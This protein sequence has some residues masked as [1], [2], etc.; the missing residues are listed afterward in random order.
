VEGDHH[1]NAREQPRHQRDEERLEVV[2]VQEPHAVRPRC[3][4]DRA[5][6]GEIEPPRALE[7]E[8]LKSAPPRF[9]RQR[10]GRAGPHDGADDRSIGRDRGL[11]ERQHRAVRA[12]QRRALAQMQDR[13]HARA[14]S[15]R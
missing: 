4:C 10:I 2:R 1:R 8:R 5:R 14:D 11:G 9:F 15:S 3:F 6:A 12:V 13:N 7:P